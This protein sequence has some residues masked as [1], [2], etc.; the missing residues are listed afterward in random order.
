MRILCL[1]LTIY[2][3]VLLARII[4]SW[5]VGFVRVPMSGPLRTLLTLLYDVT[6]PVLRPFRTLI[7]PIRM[8][9]M[10]MDLSPLLVFIIIGVL[11]RVTCR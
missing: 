10:A 4:A 1:L 6:D 3:Y 8:G 7:P 9:G 2:F 11:Q 5:V